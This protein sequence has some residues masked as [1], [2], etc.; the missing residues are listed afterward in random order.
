MQSV[1]NESQR[2]SFFG[3]PVNRSNPDDI[4]P[5]FLE[6]EFKVA[7]FVPFRA[8]SQHKSYLI[9]LASTRSYTLSRTEVCMRLFVL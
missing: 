8:L 6:R 4:N 5:L 7:E 1:C 2:Q 3:A 9:M